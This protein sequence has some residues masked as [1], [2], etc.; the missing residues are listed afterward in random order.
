MKPTF[1]DNVVGIFSP[2]AQLKRMQSKAAIEVVRKFDIASDSRRNNGWFRPKTTGAQEVSKAFDK[3]GQSSQE[4]VRNNPLAH[5]IKKVW[6]NNIAGSGIKLEVLSKQLKTA[7]KFMEDWDDWAESLDCDFEGDNNLYGLQN[8]WAG[9]VVESGG[10]FVRQHINPKLMKQGK[11]PLQ[12]QTIEQGDLDRGKNKFT[13]NGVI[14]DGVQYNGSGQKEGYWFWSEKTLTGLGKPPKSKFVPADKIVHIFRK[15]RAGQHLGMT[16]LASCGTTLRN[17]DTY[18]DAKLMQQQIAA[19]FALIFEEATSSMG[20]SGEGTSEMPDQVEPG[21]VE[22]VK[23]GTIPHTIT[24]PKA[25]NSSSFD[26]SVKR[27]AAAGA[28]ITY[29]QLTGDYSQVNFASGRMGKNEFYAELDVV[30]QT[31]FRPKL[32]VIF[33]WFK[34]IHSTLN[35]G[36]DFKPDWT[37]PARTSVNPKEELEVVLTKVRSGLLSPRRACKMFGN[38]L[39]DIIREWEKDKKEFGEMPFDIDPSKFASTGNQLDDND[40]A[41]SNSTSE[42]KKLTP[43]E[44]EKEKE[45]DNS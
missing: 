43:E 11:F 1:I 18:V 39:T 31:T 17:Y 26:T 30:Q 5:R 4:L 23:N 35:K 9:T 20:V 29:E 22:Y 32:D 14:I 19:C 24:P 42:K 41:S 3:A 28:G 8:L 16:W 7:E 15:E 45:K 37:F 44:T 21:M 10:V 2:A 13:K 6:S 27:D 40:A 34:N 12:L 36:S 25:D 33:S 38:R